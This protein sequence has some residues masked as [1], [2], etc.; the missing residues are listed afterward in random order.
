[1]QWMWQLSMLLSHCLGTLI[2]VPSTE[3]HYHMTPL[4]PASF[5]AGVIS[6]Y[7]QISVILYNAF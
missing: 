2:Y 6:E 4:H 3:G 7:V 1:M 5:V